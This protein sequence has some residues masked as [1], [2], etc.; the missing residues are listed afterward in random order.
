MTGWGRNDRTL[1]W[2]GLS[3]T[4]PILSFYGQP[5]H[6]KASPVIPVA[7]ARMTSKMRKFSLSG[8]S[9]KDWASNERFWERLD[10]TYILVQNELEWLVNEFKM[11]KLIRMI[12]L[13]WV[14]NDGMTSE[15]WN[16]IRMMEWH[17]NDGMT[18]EWWNPVRMTWEWWNDIRMIKFY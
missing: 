9:W 7:T 2:D 12:L 3:R 14:Q 8:H 11:T 18:L 5:S 15:W 1:N 4:L 13:E 16:D 6:S 17:Q 10:K